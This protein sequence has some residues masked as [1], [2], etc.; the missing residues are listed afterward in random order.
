MATSDGIEII[1]LEEHY[2][3]TVITDNYSG[4]NSTR[5]GPILERLYDLHDLRIKEMDQSGIDI[6][7]LSH[8][9]PS[10]QRLDEISG[11]M[12]TQKANNNLNEIVKTNPDRFQGFAALATAAVSYTHLTLPTNREV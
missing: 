2:W 8:G 1:A 7:V 10:A 3:D 12:I 11:P 9:A 6:Q 5:R 4:P